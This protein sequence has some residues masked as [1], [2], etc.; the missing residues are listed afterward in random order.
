[1]K[2]QLTN[3]QK[4]S[5]Q[6]ILSTLQLTLLGVKATKINRRFATAYYLGMENLMTAIH[7][8][9]SPGFWGFFHFFYWAV[10]INDTITC[11]NLVITLDCAILLCEIVGRLFVPSLH[12]QKFSL[13]RM[14]LQLRRSSAKL[15]NCLVSGQIGEFEPLSKFT[16]TQSTSWKCD[17][18]WF[19][20]IS[21]GNS[22]VF[23][24]QNLQLVRRITFLLYLML[25]VSCSTK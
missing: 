25:C 2:V 8:A 4:C 12:C 13:T 23:F 9:V 6:D 20:I 7:A 3:H 22:L 15:T 14:F 10:Y 18:V 24:G 19:V 21:F 16:L 5:K 17:F 1:M 11:I